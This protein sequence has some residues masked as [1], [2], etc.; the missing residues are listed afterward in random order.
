MLAPMADGLSGYSL[1]EI[2]ARDRLVRRQRATAPDD[3]GVAREYVITR[4]DAPPSAPLGGVEAAAEAARA[5][6]DDR[7]VPI[8]AVGRDAS[9]Q[10]F[11]AC[12]RVAG[13]SL[14][15]RLAEGP[16]EEREAIWIALDIARTLAAAHAIVP[17]LV[18]G[19]IRESAIWID[20]EG[21]ARLDDY[22]FGHAM[23][24]VAQGDGSILEATARFHSPEHTQG[25]PLLPGS[26]VFA[27]ASVLFEAVSGRPA[28]EADSPVGVLMRIS[29]GKVPSGDAKIGLELSGILTSCWA[30]QPKKRAT[31][32]GLVSALEELA[33]DVD[34]R[35]PPEAPPAPVYVARTE[36]EQAQDW[37]DL[38]TLLQTELPNHI[39]EGV[40]LGRSKRSSDPPD[41]DPNAAAPPPRPAELT[42]PLFPL[43][44]QGMPDDVPTMRGESMVLAEILA[45][46]ERPAPKRF[47]PPPPMPAW[48]E[49]AEVGTPS[50]PPPALG[51]I[52][53][54]IGALL[55]LM[56]L[57]ILILLLAS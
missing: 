55:A 17:S 43:P 16:L 19:G 38:P 33:G 45:S 50:G 1:G 15:E 52:L 42:H 37:L 8:H 20:D 40:V 32:A 18:H 29:L 51:W 36:E 30:K 2:L 35:R 11:V 3:R 9:G 5:L 49:P 31:A 27:L 14:D 57:T 6:P 41:T 13:K 25:S 56:L 48:T 4:C 47:E 21:F 7:I 10:P 53:V 54:G 39:P 24:Q 26:D 22:A 28:F 23:G 44:E 12:K 46:A 34:P